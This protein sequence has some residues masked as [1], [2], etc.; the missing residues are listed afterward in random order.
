MWNILNTR[1]QKTHICHHNSFIGIKSFILWYPILLNNEKLKSQQN[2]ENYFSFHLF[3]ITVNNALRINKDLHY[4]NVNLLIRIIWITIQHR[5]CRIF[6]VGFDN[7]FK[8][9][10]NLRKF[11]EIFAKTIQKWFH[12]RRSYGLYFNFFAKPF[13]KFLIDF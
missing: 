3:V 5:L 2:D 1:L 12:L 6:V 9:V 13:P 7:N 11:G 10:L 8:P 4:K